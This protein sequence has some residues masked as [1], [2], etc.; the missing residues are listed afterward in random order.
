M[1]APA[2]LTAGLSLEDSAPGWIRTTVPVGPVLQTGA[3]G[4]TMRP[5]R[6]GWWD[7]NPTWTWL[8]TKRF[9]PSASSSVGGAGLEPAHGTACDAAALPLS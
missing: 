8:T 4:Q 6:G 3:I 7:L 9:D 2:C 5:A 1:P